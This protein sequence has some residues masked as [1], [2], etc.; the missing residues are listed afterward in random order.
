M[1]DHLDDAL[2]QAGQVGPLALDVVA[3]REVEQPLGDALT[4]ERLLLDHLQ[5]VGDDPVIGMFRGTQQPV[6]AMLERL[7]AE[8]DRGQRVVD[9]VRDP[10]GQEADARQPL[11]ADEL[12]APLL[13]LAA[14]GRRRS[15]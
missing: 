10:G 13:D 6:E 9:L 8:G 5:V 14:R 12:A 7:G 15:R 2:D 3:A 11:G 4:A 1:A